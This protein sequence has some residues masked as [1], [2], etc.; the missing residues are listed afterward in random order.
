[1]LYNISIFLYIS[2][3]KLKY[4]SRYNSLKQ[5]DRYCTNGYYIWCT[6]PKTLLR[7]FHSVTCFKTSSKM[8]SSYLSIRTQY[9]PL[10]WIVLPAFST[11]RRIYPNIHLTLPCETNYYYIYQMRRNHSFQLGMNVPNMS[12]K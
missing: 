5:I 7:Q 11:G 1:M 8:V 6:L 9:R 12:I 2:K 3:A 4:M 10:R